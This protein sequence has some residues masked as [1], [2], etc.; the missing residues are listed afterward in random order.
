MTHALKIRSRQ[1]KMIMLSMIAVV[2]LGGLAAECG[3]EGGMYQGGGDSEPGWR[4]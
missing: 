4:R 1:L 3:G 2:A